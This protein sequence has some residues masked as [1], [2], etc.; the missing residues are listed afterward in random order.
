MH[1]TVYS[2]ETFFSDTVT[3]SIR[4]SSWWKTLTVSL[5]GD[6]YFAFAGF[7]NLY[8]YVKIHLKSKL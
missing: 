2:Y 3:L 5:S 1:L 6:E 7:C 4:G 8:H